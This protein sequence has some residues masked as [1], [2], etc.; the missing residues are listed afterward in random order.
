MLKTAALSVMAAVIALLLVASPAVVVGAGFDWGSGCAGG[1]GEFTTKL[2]KKNEIVTIGTL[3]KGKWNV[4]VRLSATSDVDVQLYDLSDSSTFSEGKAIVAYCAEDGCN[5]GPLGNNDGSKEEAKYKGM[6]VQYSGYYG[7]NKNPGKEYIHIIGEL[8]E[9]LSMKAFAFATGDAKIEYQWGKSQTGCCLGTAACTG[10]FSSPVPKG[11]VVTIGEIPRDKKNL[12]VELDAEQDVD[13]QL[14]DLEDTS[15]FSEGKAIIAYCEAKD[16]NKGALGNNDGTEESTVY[17]G[18]TYTYS[19]YDGVGGQK[20]KEFIQLGGVTST[21]LNMKAFGYE[22]GV[23]QIKYSYYEPTEGIDVHDP[24]VSF[25]ESQNAR[26]HSTT[27]YADKPKGTLIVRRAATVQAVARHPES[28]AA[29]DVT[30]QIGDLEANKPYPS[31]MYTTRTTQTSAGEVLVEVALAADAPIGKYT[32]RITVAQP[33]KRFKVDAPIVILV[34]PYKSSDAGY[35]SSSYRAEYVERTTGLIWQ[36][37]S[38][39]YDAFRFDYNQFQWSNLLVAIRSLR[40]MPIADRGNLVLVTRHLTY[41]AGEDICY[42]KWGEGSYTTGKP[43]GGYR[44]SSTKPCFGPDH[45]VSMTDLIDLHV[46]LGYKNVQYCQCFVYAGLMTTLG[47]ALGMATRP[48]STFQS[49]HDTEK[50][51]AIEKFFVIN[52]EADGAFD[53]VKD[54]DISTDSVWSFHVWNEIYFKRTDIDCKQFGS[55]TSSTCANGWQAVDATPQEESAGGSGVD[56]AQYQMGPASVKLV[57]ENRDPT[58]DAQQD[59]KYG[60]FDNEF[61]ISEVNS[62]VHVWLKDDKEPTGWKLYAGK[63]FLQDPWEDQY[64]TIGFL[65]A[66][67]KR[68]E[69]SAECLAT[70]DTK[71]CS[72]DLDDVTKYYKK[73]EPSGPGETTLPACKPGDDASKA[74]SGPRFETDGRR[75]R[76]ARSLDEEERHVNFSPGFGVSPSLSGA[77]INENMHAH[78]TFT[79][80]IAFAALED[81]TVV[82]NFVAT[83]VDYRGYPYSNNSEVGR[84]AVS[85]SVKK[86]ENATC[87]QEFLRDDYRRFVDDEMEDDEKAY[88]IK[89]VA[90][91]R[92]GGQ[93]FAWEHQK[94]LCTPLKTLRSGIICEARRGKWKK[95]VGDSVNI[96][97]LEECKTAGRVNDGFCDPDLN[98]EENCYDGGDCCRTSC[99]ARNGGLTTLDFDTMETIYL[100]E[101]VDDAQCADPAF[102]G[103]AG[104]PIEYAVDAAPSVGAFDDTKILEK[105]CEA[106]IAERAGSSFECSG[107]LLLCPEMED[108]YPQVAAFL[109]TLDSACSPPRC[110]RESNSESAEWTKDDEAAVVDIIDVVDFVEMAQTTFAPTVPGDETLSPTH[111]DPEGSSTWTYVAI[112]IAVAGILCP[113]AYFAYAVKFKAKS[114]SGRESEDKVVELGDIAMGTNKNAKHSRALSQL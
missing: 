5:K 7:V 2:T 73:S 94:M 49:A 10:S 113:V 57:K 45:W 66:T 43:A 53:P 106:R 103:G 108:C 92:V 20:G 1:S 85:V 33:T 52:E 46:K 9:D 104:A 17:K 60:C 70:D 26:A 41:A 88:A 105:D 36:G 34:N 93:I 90:T 38:D 8:T 95:P 61:V 14:Y 31:D 12:R 55:R 83:A 27:M 15:T 56:G 100:C 30:A 110:P 13:I 4:K 74:C 80:R 99:E 71:D 87:S 89:I 112:G 24:A 42:G 114:P 64:N 78:S 48:V 59:P 6:V 50:N 54:H 69:I 79:P 11:G 65:V 81:T 68:G 77:I 97:H 111:V 35:A 101:D 98:N 84:H 18:L 75:V 58:C 72:K 86:G 47:R 32:L 23:A 25:L 44:C 76:R 102:S 40:R 96:A 82:C 21:K 28:I 22:A 3:P 29:S 19:G 91:A 107:A 16:C 109:K 62:N 39:N 63:G 67:K 51:R 37:L